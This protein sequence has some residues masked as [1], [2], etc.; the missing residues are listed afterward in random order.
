MKE[1][2]HDPFENFTKMDGYDD[3]I[4]GL[5]ERCGQED[6]LCYNRDKVIDKLMNGG[7]TRKDAVEYYYYNQVGAYMGENTPCFITLFPKSMIPKSKRIR[8]VKL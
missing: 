8:K 3:C 5:V 4:I 7:M 6:I 2:T 1:K